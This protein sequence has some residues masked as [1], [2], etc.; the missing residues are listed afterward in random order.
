ME[1]ITAPTRRD[2]IKELAVAIVRRDGLINL[3][4]SELCSVADMPD[5]SFVHVMGCSFTEFVEELRKDGAELY[6]MG[7]LSKKRASKELRKGHLLAVALHMAR[8][9]GYQKVTRSAIAETAGVSVGLVNR[10]F[11]TMQQLRRDVMR[12]AVRS[13]AAD[14]V[15]QGLAVGDA[16]AAKAPDELKEQAARAIYAGS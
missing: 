8:S 1:A 16:Q 11:G 12:E 15:A 13:G 3:T 4:R 5:G 14:V 7:P 2:K 6:R 10:Y 9:A